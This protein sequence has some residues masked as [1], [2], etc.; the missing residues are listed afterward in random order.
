MTVRDL[1]VAADT[2]AVDAPPQKLALTL[3]RTYD[4]YERGRVNSARCVDFVD[5]V[6]T[7]LSTN[8]TKSA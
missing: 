3:G 1:F 2:A 6:Q 4:S 7:D 5:F 8:E